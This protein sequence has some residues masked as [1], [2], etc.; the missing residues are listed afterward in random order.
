MDSDGLING[1]NPIFND[2]L[3]FLW[4]KMGVCPRD[5]LLKATKD[6]YKLE[7]ICSA[8]EL[9][10]KH[11]PNSSDKRRTMHRKQDDILSALYLEF[12]GLPSDH[13]LIFVALNLNNIPSVNLS[14][15]D[16]ATL[17]FKQN[18]LNETIEAIL[19]ENKLF[20]EELSSIKTML[21]NSS[22]VPTLRHVAPVSE[23][24]L[25]PSR[26]PSSTNIDNVRGGVNSGQLIGAT[27]LNFSDALRNP[28]RG[29]SR[30]IRTV[31][32]NRNS[33]RRRLDTMGGT[34]LQPSQQIPRQ[35]EGGNGWTTVHRNRPPRRRRDNTVT[36]TKSG[37]E[38]GAIP[39]L[40]KCSIFV[41][42]L[43][44]S[45]SVAKI[46][47]FVKQII[48]NSECHVEKLNTKFDTY[49]SFYVSC[50]DKFKE[51]LLDPVMWESGILVKPFYGPVR[52]TNLSGEHVQS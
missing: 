24:T 13:E 49:A 40:K 35:E 30:L 20:R 4:N 32:E 42:R 14:N 21:E 12:Q 31:S 33:A 27:A 19:E 41:S 43:N 10:H 39:K 26:G 5:P 44:P 16:G 51:K 1:M 50:E 28:P 34:D 3:A 9:F 15:I 17:V 45:V 46:L 25:Q 37:N 22:A 11:V 29:G 6:F 38:L 2:L 52:K 18:S 47:E 7:D 8:R 48:D 23:P 36:G